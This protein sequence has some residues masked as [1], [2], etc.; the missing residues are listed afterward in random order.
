MSVASSPDRRKVSILL[1]EPIHRSKIDCT[2]AIPLSP[3]ENIDLDDGNDGAVP[4]FIDE[5]PEDES[6]RVYTYGWASTLDEEFIRSFCSEYGN[7]KL[8]KIITGRNGSNGAYVTF[9]T[10][11]EVEKFLQAISDHPK[12]HARKAGKDIQKDKAIIK[13]RNLDDPSAGET[14]AMARYFE[15]EYIRTEREEDMGFHKNEKPKKNKKLKQKVEESGYDLAKIACVC[16]AIRFLGTR[17]GVPLFG[18][19]WSNTIESVDSFADADWCWIYAQIVNESRNSI[20]VIY[21]RFKDV[22]EPPQNCDGKWP[23]TP[24]EAFRYSFLEYVDRDDVG[25]KD[26]ERVCQA[27]LKKDEEERREEI[28]KRLDKQ[29]E[30]PRVGYKMI[31][32]RYPNKGSR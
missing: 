2:Q 8:I 27:I 30:F 3:A 6:L 25:A 29:R 4:L 22:A 17:R 16:K 28:S 15:R 26:K 10:S 9:S 5:E 23:D 18:V 11:A 12:L 20:K 14:Q 1:P 31:G 13:Y 7:P 24:E 21:D 19:E 32:K